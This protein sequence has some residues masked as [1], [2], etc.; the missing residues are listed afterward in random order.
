MQRPRVLIPTYRPICLAA[1]AIPGTGFPSASDV[2]WGIAHVYFLIGLR[3]RIA[4]AF[5]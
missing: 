3:N 5:S 1:G 2:V 4:V